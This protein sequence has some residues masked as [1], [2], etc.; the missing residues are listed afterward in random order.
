MPGHTV[1]TGT[2]SFRIH[3]LLHDMA[4]H[5]LTSPKTP[6]SQWDIPGLG[7]TLSG[8]HDA[9]LSRYRG[10]MAPGHWHALPDDGYLYDQLTWHL[11]QSGSLDD[12]HAL[13][14]ESTR[15]ETN[16][17]YEARH[18]AGQVA[19][20]IEDVH[21]AW[22]IAERQYD[23]G[24]P[25]RYI[26]LQLKY[27]LVLTS[28][29]S[30]ASRIRP[31]LLAAAVAKE[32]W[33]PEQA[34]AYAQQ[35]PDAV[36]R[37]ESITLLAPRLPVGLLQRALSA[38]SMIED[39]K[40]KAIALAAVAERLPASY[41][42]ADMRAEIERAT[43]IANEAAE[44]ARI[45]RARGKPTLSVT[46]TRE[47]AR[48]ATVASDIYRRNGANA[49]K[50][51][52]REI[53]GLDDSGRAH[54]LA[55]LI[56][57]ASP[58]DVDTLLTE[59]EKIKDDVARSRVLVALATKLPASLMDRALTIASSL[60]SESQR[61]ECVEH[62]QGQLDKS[63][64]HDLLL[65]SMVI[66]DGH[67]RER[68][69]RRLYATLNETRLSARRWAG[70][71][72]LFGELA[73]LAATLLARMLYLLLSRDALKA[74]LK[75]IHVAIRLGLRLCVFIGLLLLTEVFLVLTGLERAARES[76]DLRTLRLGQGVALVPMYLVVR[77]LIPTGRKNLSLDEP[78]LGSDSV[79]AILRMRANLI[80]SM[81]FRARHPGSEA[82]A[83]LRRVV[84]RGANGRTDVKSVIDLARSLDRPLLYRAYAI[85]RG[86]GD[87]NTKNEVLTALTS[88]IAGSGEAQSRSLYAEWCTTLH[89]QSHGTRES[90]INAMN[91]DHHLTLLIEALGGE[92]GLKEA[93]A[94]VEN[95]GLWWP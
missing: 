79:T 23:P 3:A 84:R 52:L 88:I 72:S 63:A 47:A 89:N 94:A 87:D 19:G 51:A 9:L 34:L 59:A 24:A 78:L 93:A 54:V 45:A 2:V 27:A 70:R 68:L 32:V 10:R 49:I 80:L 1:V 81:L 41:I 38:A 26:G 50:S 91:N 48:A 76:G 25:N 95:V 8:A 18:T 15:K 86:F 21:R 58:Q 83:R 74:S 92:S 14:D 75:L 64:I 42:K 67:G 69:L 57:R 28:L 62:I 36:H 33:P 13:L 90:A 40:A 65:S 4:R 53:S 16:G 20:Y 12:V 22:R 46:Q 77:L 61:H 29:S 55:T 71:C 37:A 56:H 44:W 66:G 17:W 82:I 85:A 7:L 6:K 5:L 43:R 60:E 35:V 30:L 73:S 11:E 39:P 31:S